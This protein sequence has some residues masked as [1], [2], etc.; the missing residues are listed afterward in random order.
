MRSRTVRT[1]LFSWV[2]LA[3]C[4]GPGRA[5]E[6]WLHVRVEE[7]RGGSRVSVNLPMAVVEAA[8]PLLRFAA[9]HS[10][11]TVRIN[12]CR[13]RVGDL[14]NAWRDLEAS[15][16][17]TFVTIEDGAEHVRVA[18]VGNR[19]IVRGRHTSE[20]IEMRIPGRV[21]DALLGGDGDELDLAAGLRALVAE[22]TG[23]LVTVDDHDDQ[24]RVWVDSSSEAR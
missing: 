24:V 9:I 23:D 8:A 15:P 1:L 20:R 14:R 17:G 13:W 21:V 11:S 6:N 3:L 10:P 4:A 16:D 2:A 22:G 18:K 5:T 19:I 7:A 12:G